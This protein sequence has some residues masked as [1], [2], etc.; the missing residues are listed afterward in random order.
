MIAMDD[1]IKIEVD[2]IFPGPVPDQ[3]GVQIEL[4]HDKLTVLIQMPELNRD[5]L[6]AFNKGFEQYSYL[7]SDTPI[8]VALWIFDFPDPFSSIEGNFNAKRARRKWLDLYL[9][10][11][12]DDTIK[13]A[14]QFFLLDGQILRAM[15]LIELDP[16]AV[17]LFHGTIR[18][19]LDMDYNRI[20]FDRYLAGLHNYDTQDL[21][22][23]GKVFKQTLCSNSSTRKLFLFLRRWL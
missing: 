20:D 7:E 11:G 23:M 1:F 10:A 13:K 8:P 14:I 6:R 16:E 17:E 3:E 19:Q 12:D 21:F 5:Q 15:K 4:W 9:D 18:K 22:R 2:K